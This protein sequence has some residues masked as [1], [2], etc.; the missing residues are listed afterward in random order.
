[1]TTST[2]LLTRSNSTNKKLPQHSY[3]P[4]PLPQFSSPNSN[5]HDY[6]GH[7]HTRSLTSLPSPVP[8]LPAPP[9][10]G[11]EARWKTDYDTS[12]ESGSEI[13]RHTSQGLDNPK[14]WDASKLSEY[15]HL[16][17]LSSLAEYV[18]ANNISGRSFLR[19]S[20]S[21]MMPHSAEGLTDDQVAEML[22][23]ARKLRILALK[24]RI[25]GLQASGDQEEY[26]SMSPI[27][28]PIQRVK[29][30]GMVQAFEKGST[31]MR[32]DSSASSD[33]DWIPKSPL[34][35]RAASPHDLSDRDDLASSSEA[36]SDNGFAARRV[37]DSRVSST[38]AMSDLRTPSP[39]AEYVKPIIRG[40]SD[41]FSKE[42]SIE[43][44]LSHGVDT[45][46]S[47]GT[48]SKSWGAKAWE[49]D[50]LGATARRV[51]LSPEKF[52]PSLD[53]FGVINLKQFLGE[54]VQE[55][56]VNDH[57][58]HP[59]EPAVGD[60]VADTNITA[61]AEKLADVTLVDSV[62]R[63]STSPISE[64]SET[65]EELKARVA[66]LEAR[67]K[68]LEQ[69]QETEE[70]GASN[71]EEGFSPADMNLPEYLLMAGVGVCAIIGQAVLRKFMR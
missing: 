1:V 43:E 39:P 33:S 52:G 19:F 49:E 31:R 10:S 30:K 40:P 38:G 17:D 56:E 65:V 68:G 7:R 50:N 41:E 11:D 4:S 8:A 6:R 61:D 37:P 63:T 13:D 29:V 9:S 28:S 44:L 69:S 59:E 58:P 62:E 55:E 5:R 66:A 14:N 2:A 15:L 23:Q 27:A 25:R 64:A 26:E 36:E 45:S 16:Q 54:K 42:P 12:S 24:T 57:T 35:R 51:P 53:E 67:I 46:D 70:S 20:P 3:S 32:S 60:E 22:D 48:L 21:S 47:F 71:K 34:K 18:E